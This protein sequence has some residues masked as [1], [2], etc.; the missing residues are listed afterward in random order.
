MNSKPF[1]YI[2]S[3]PCQ[4]SLAIL[5]CVAVVSI[6]ESWDVNMHT[7]WCIRPLSWSVSWCLAECLGNGDRRCYMD[8]M[9][10]EQLNFFCV[11]IVGIFALLSQEDYRKITVERKGEQ[12]F[13]T[14][15]MIKS[16]M[17][18]VV[19]VN[20]HQTVQVFYTTMLSHIHVAFF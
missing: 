13:F 14:S 3:D 19:A 7:A 16:C 2:T 4:L 18:K 9:V 15:E 17:K 11:L 8:P 10:W 5:L 1:C 12:N 6:S 20:L